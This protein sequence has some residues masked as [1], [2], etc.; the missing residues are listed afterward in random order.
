MKGLRV[1]VLGTTFNIHSKP[2]SGG[3]EVTLTE[4]SVSLFAD[5]NSSGMADRVLSPGQQALYATADNTFEI[6]TIRPEMYSSWVT[7]K[8]LF[9]NNSLWEIVSSLERA[10]NTHIY[11]ED[12]ALKHMRLTAQF[13]HQETLDEI[14]SILQTSAKYKYRKEKGRIYITTK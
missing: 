7:G 9:E 12:E 8:F 11:I 2:E 1:Q 5:A 3:I 14:L 13:T 4:G 6:R 10:F